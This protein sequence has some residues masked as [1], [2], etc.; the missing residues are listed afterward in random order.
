MAINK[1]HEFEELN[2]VKCAIVEKNASQERVDFLR[3]LLEWNKFT[4]VVVPSAPPKPAPAPVVTTEASEAALPPP[5]PPPTTFTIG[6]TDVTF[7][8]VNAIFGRLL[9]TKDG[10][11]V[12]LA[13]WQQKETVAH[14]EI[15][16]FENL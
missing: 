7:N 4:V 16:Y 12:T 3:D 9:K 8:W 15:P 1:N 11:V 13:Y 6:V 5:P 14:D 10:H 2:G